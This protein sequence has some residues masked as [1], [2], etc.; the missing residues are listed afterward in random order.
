MRWM[1]DCGCAEWDWLV[2]TLDYQFSF[3]TSMY[4]QHYIDLM[5]DPQPNELVENS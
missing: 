3:L 1:L 4:K 5:I 2:L